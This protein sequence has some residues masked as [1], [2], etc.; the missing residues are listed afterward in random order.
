MSIPCHLAKGDLGLLP[1]GMLDWVSECISLCQP[2]DLYI[3]D[4][5]IEED[6][7]LKVATALP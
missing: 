2:Q 1:P 5:T 6:R 4:G 3:M 7:E